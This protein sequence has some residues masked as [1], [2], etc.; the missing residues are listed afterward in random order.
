MGADFQVSHQ[1]RGLKPTGYQQA[2]LRDAEQ[3]GRIANRGLKPT[4]TIVPSL[5]DALQPERKQFAAV[6]LP[7]LL[8]VKWR[9]LRL[10][11]C[12]LSG[13]CRQLALGAY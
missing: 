13:N 11:R 2:S 7:D 6:R 8:A 4:A 9:T 10:E 5:R 1:A 12:P 3:F